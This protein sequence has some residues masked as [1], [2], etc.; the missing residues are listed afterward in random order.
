MM[1]HHDLKSPD[2]ASGL[3]AVES[4]LSF[5][6]IAA[7]IP[8]YR[9]EA[10]I[11]GVITSIP[12]FVRTIIVVDD[13]SPDR[14]NGVVRGVLDKEPRG[15]LL[16][17]ARNRGVGAAMVTGVREALA[18]GAE[19]VV[20]VDGDGQMAGE[21]II[22][23]LIPLVEG[24]ADFSKGNRFRDARALQAMPLLRRI[25]NAGLS[26]CAKAATGYWDCFDPTNG[27]LAMRGDVLS[28]LPLAR[29]A[30][31]Y[32]FEISLLGEL[33]LLQAVVSDVPIPARY[34][35]EKSSLSIPRVLVTF[36]WKLAAMLARR[37]LLKYFVYDFT[38]GS[39][40]I[41]GGLP[42][43]AFGLVFGMTNWIKYA[44]QGVPAP[45][46][47]VMLA[48]LPFILGFQL[49]LSAISFD[50]GSMPR[51]PLGTSMLPAARRADSV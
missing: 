46:G 39:L 12:S 15:V 42:L 7:V 43:L 27:F 4:D 44:S 36:P 13:A 48:T 51:R 32:F 9:V 5:L 29:V 28:R 45:T 25:G 17:H 21:G 1:E 14:T 19:I 38:V 11:A 31:G 24:R 33:Y 6:H 35:K 16:S 22:D 37:I 3:S 34:G 49:L 2:R 40:Y 30:P 23:L 50:L 20:K 8:A 41:A 10:Q 47:T 18:R 26:F